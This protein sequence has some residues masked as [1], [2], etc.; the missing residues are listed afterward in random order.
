[1]ALSSLNVELIRISS[2]VSMPLTGEPSI[3]T[4]NP[5]N[6]TSLTSE[7]TAV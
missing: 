1:M 2:R 4:Q 7:K 5:P 6:A 3:E